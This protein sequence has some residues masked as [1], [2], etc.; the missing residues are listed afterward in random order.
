MTILTLALALCCLAG[1]TAGADA[2][3]TAA[4]PIA[5]QSDVGD[6][7]EGSRT[8]LATQRAFFVRGGLS[9]FTAQFG[10]SY[11]AG[12]G[13][14]GGFLYGWRDNLIIRA[15]LGYYAF[16]TTDI[17]GAPDASS[18]VALMPILVGADY[19]LS[20]RSSIVPYIGAAIG[21]TFLQADFEDA[22]NGKFAYADLFEAWLGAEGRLGA[23]MRRPRSRWEATAELAYGVIWD[24]LPEFAM[25]DPSHHDYYKIA[26]GITYFVGE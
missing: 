9:S 18:D 21:P 26:A 23:W 22:G 14:E 2:Q 24:E 8:S 13:G 20:T 11:G 1:W 4:P 7:D 15:S 5:R 19:L 3:I 12:F 10:D 25:G 17:A 16:S 6:D